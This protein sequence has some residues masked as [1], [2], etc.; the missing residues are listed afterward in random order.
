MDFQSGQDKE[1]MGNA[2]ANGTTV[3]SEQSLELVNLEKKTEKVNTELVER[4]L[5]YSISE[6]PPFHI[7]LVCAFQVSTIFCICAY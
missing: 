5:T 7:T 2:D 4:P 1:L 6:T 3:L